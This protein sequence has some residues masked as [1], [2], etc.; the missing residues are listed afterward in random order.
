MFLNIKEPDPG[1]NTEWTGSKPEPCPHSN[2]ESGTYRTFFTRICFISF[3]NYGFFVCCILT[4]HTK[5]LHLL[6]G[7]SSIV[8]TCYFHDQTGFLPLCTKRCKENASI[9]SGPW[10]QHEH[11]AGPGPRVPA[12]VQG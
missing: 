5:G 9:N 4:I 12:Q 7:F 8:A 2:P 10:I 11:K 3:L 1:K 6:E